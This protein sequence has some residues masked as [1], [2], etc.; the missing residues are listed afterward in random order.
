[1]GKVRSNKMGISTKITN[2]EYLTAIDIIKQYHEQVNQIIIDIDN[3]T[4]TTMP[5]FFKD[6]VRNMS[7][8]L[9][10]TISSYIDGSGRHYYNGDLFDMD[11]LEDLEDIDI[12][13]IRNSG[14]KTLIEFKKLREE[15]LL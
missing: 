13:R 15:Y 2:L 7:I 8:R 1:M 9:R 5:K 14:K 12:L 6:N 11:H 10:N 3:S 4:K